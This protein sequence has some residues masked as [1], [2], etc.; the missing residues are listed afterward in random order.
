MHFYEIY[1]LTVSSNDA[2]PELEPRRRRAPGKADLFVTIK[3]PAPRLERSSNHRFETV[4]RRASLELPD[5]GRY[6]VRDGKEI[7]VT[8]EPVADPALVRLFLLGSVI[9]LA[10]HQRGL[11]PLHASA[12]AVNGRA[13][14]FVGDEGQGKSTLA[15]HCLACGADSLVADDVVVVSRDSSDTWWAQPGMPSLKLWRDALDRLSQ[16]TDDLRPDWF[17]ADKFHLPQSGGIAQRPMPLSGIY[18]LESD[19]NAGAGRI[20]PINGSAATVLLIAHTYRMEILEPTQQ[21]AS[22][23][24]ACTHLA[25]TIPVRRLLRERDPRKIGD[26]TAMLLTDVARGLR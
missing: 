13:I 14:A 12:V 20:E 2:L 22:H 9:G 24:A 4:P 25:A 1:G 23:F 19:P 8:P 10:L 15:A 7:V 18:V 26:T 3:R 11:L 6:E 5:V 21:R 17:R 16:P